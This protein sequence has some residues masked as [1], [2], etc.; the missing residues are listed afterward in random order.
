MSNALANPERVSM[1]SEAHAHPSI[2]LFRSDRLER[3]TVISPRAF[4]LTWIGVI[5]LVLFASWRSAG[6]AASIGLAAAGLVGWSLFEY[7]MH[8]FLFHWKARSQMFQSVVFVTHGNHHA[9]PNDPHRNLMPVI[10]S[11]PVSAV[12]WG[13]SLLALGRPGSLFFLG[14]ITGY[15]LYDSIH[16]ACHQFP[17][18]RGLLR[19]LRRHHIRHHYA[20]REGNYAITAILWDWVFG[21][22]I[23]AKG[24]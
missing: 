12:I 2:R 8:R 21:T 7:A 18:R 22:Q 20:K 19:H 4:A 16:Y 15:V 9:D 1:S 10:V 24:R 11:V 6:V 5:A 14:F 23:S 17:M 13:C 3:L